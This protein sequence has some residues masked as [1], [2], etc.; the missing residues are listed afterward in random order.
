VQQNFYR[1]VDSWI[2]QTIAFGFYGCFLACGFLVIDEKSS[3]KVYNNFQ[4]H[5]A[6]TFS[7]PKY[8]NVY[9]KRYGDT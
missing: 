4:V 5:G 2:S 8:A 9:I 3:A 1:L 6:S 7:S